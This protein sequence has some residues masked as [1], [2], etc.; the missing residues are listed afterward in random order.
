MT[1]AEALAELR[2]DGGALGARGGVAEGVEVG[3]E[4]VQD[5]V[6]RRDNA[7][8]TRLRQQYQVGAPVSCSTSYGFP[9]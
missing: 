9:R 7:A 1:G 6:T 2:H 5:A 3:A 4:V 8:F